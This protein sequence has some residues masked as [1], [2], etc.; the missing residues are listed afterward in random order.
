MPVPL[1]GEICRFIKGQ[2][3]NWNEHTNRPRP[4]GF[5]DNRAS[6]LSVWDVD[7]LKINNLQLEELLAEHFPGQGQAFLTVRDCIDAAKEVAESHNAQFNIT[8]ER[9]AASVPLTMSRWSFA[10]VQVEYPQSTPDPI[11]AKF[12][13]LLAT[14]SKNVVP[15]AKYHQ[16]A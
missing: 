1:N 6:N 3:N 7:A 5:K 15:P 9:N 13:Q 16:G 8:V 14:K 11:L 2:S 12:R 4:K 10:H